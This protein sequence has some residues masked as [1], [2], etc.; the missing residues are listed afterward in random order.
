M[1]SLQNKKFPEK[2]KD[3]VAEVKNGRIAAKNKK[4]GVYAG[5]LVIQSL[6]SIIC[7]SSEKSSIAVSAASAS[8]AAFPAPAEQVAAAST[9]R[10]CSRA[11]VTSSRSSSK[12]SREASRGRSTPTASCRSRATAR[13]RRP[14][15]RQAAQQQSRHRSTA[16]AGPP[17]PQS[18][19]SNAAGKLPPFMSVHVVV[20]CR[21]RH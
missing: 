21:V 17:P 7:V 2:D 13:S 6:L 8:P 18:H 11:C 16:A 9:T 12:A 10:A 4:L 15:L 14:L 19:S 3:V 20:T 1:V 5:A